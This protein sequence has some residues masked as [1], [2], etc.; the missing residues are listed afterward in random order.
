MVQKHLAEDDL[1]QALGNLQTA[2]NDASAAFEKAEKGDSDAGT[3]EAEPK[4]EA[5][6]RSQP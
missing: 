6:T 2:Y 1:E 4:Q 3:K 5:E